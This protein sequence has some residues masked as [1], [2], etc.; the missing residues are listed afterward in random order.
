MA[1][2]KNFHQK[3]FFGKVDYRNDVGMQFID[4]IFIATKENVMTK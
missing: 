3:F 4:K 1:M 2:A